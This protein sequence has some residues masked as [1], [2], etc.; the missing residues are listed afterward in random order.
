MEIQKH[1]AGPKEGGINKDEG[2][3]VKTKFW[4]PFLKEL[5]KEDR[6]REQER[7]INIRQNEEITSNNDGDNNIVT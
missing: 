4:V 6:K 3:Y 7:T 1:G 2:M 5:Q